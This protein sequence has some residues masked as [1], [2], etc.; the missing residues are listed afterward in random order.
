MEGGATKVS[1]L[2][3]NNTT[4]T[5]TLRKMVNMPFMIS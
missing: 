4:A 1:D 3:S 2:V 5:M